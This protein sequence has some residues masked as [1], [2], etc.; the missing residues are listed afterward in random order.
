MN[1]KTINNLKGDIDSLKQELNVLNTDVQDIRLDN[2]GINE[3][4][5]NRSSEIAR[6]KAEI[7]DLADN[8]N[9]IQYEKRDLEGQVRF[10]VWGNELI[11]NPFQGRYGSILSLKTP[12]LVSIRAKLSD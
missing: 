7:T 6:L 8:N 11:K 2:N 9:R 12:E 10:C 1:M 5:N 3:V 4:I